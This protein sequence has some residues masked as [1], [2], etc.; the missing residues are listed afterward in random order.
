MRFGGG[1]GLGAE[2]PGVARLRVADLRV[3]EVAHP[4]DDEDQECS[5][6]DLAH[7]GTVGAVPLDDPVTLGGRAPRRTCG[8]RRRRRVGWPVGGPGAVVAGWGSGAGAARGSASRARPLRS[9][10][11]VRPEALRAQRLLRRPRTQRPV[12]IVPDADR[13]ASPGVEPLG[14]TEPS[15]P[16]AADLGRDRRAP[17]DASVTGAR[18]SACCRRSR[19]RRPTSAACRGRPSGGTSPVVWPRRRCRP[20]RPSLRVRS[21]PYGRLTKPTRG[22]SHESGAACAV[23]CGRWRSGSNRT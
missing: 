8:T 10:G 4:E 13:R 15:A 22:P 9:L 19:P 3:A 2:R 11:S 5:D 20:S 1:D 23:V 18:A 17:M 12:L 16:G 14:R 21:R 7:V 6:H